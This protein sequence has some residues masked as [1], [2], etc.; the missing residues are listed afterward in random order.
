[1][2]IN[3]IQWSY[4]E[5]VPESAVIGGTD[6]DGATLYVGR[7]SHKGDQIPAKVIPANRVA[8]FPYKGKELTSYYCWVLLGNN[9]SWVPSSFGVVPSNAVIGGTTEAGE[10]L[11]IGRALH[12]GRLTP[13]VI[14]PSHMTL[15]IPFNDKAISYKNYE[16]LVE[17]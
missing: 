14:K 16:V 8:Y 10:L 6:V 2:G 3:W 13:G 7:V 5:S 9:V 1:M 17:N 12:N 15:Y 11:Y 4:W